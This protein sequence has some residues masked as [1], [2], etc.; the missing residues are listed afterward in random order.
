MVEDER[1]DGGGGDGE[2]I[3]CTLRS[4]HAGKVSGGN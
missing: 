1:G 3:A 2:I 4:N